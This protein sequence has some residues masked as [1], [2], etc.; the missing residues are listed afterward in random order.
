MGGEGVGG[1]ERK[2]LNVRERE[3]ESVCYDTSILHL[4]HKIHILMTSEVRSSTI[5]VVT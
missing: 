1:R 5:M 4:T 3:R 2:R